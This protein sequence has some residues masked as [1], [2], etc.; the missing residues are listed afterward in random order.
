MSVL[1]FYT[2]RARALCVEEPS[3]D[4]LPLALALRYDVVNTA[5]D[6]PTIGATIDGRETR[7]VHR[8]PPP[9]FCCRQCCRHRHSVTPSRDP[10][11]K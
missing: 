3:S 2:L 8:M 11:M 7:R 1:S 6:D 5:A 9:A 4:G 10:P